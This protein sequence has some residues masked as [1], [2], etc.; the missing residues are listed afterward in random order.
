MKGHGT[1]IV[2]GIKMPINTIIKY[3]HDHF[4]ICESLLHKWLSLTKEEM[5]KVMSGR[6]ITIES[7]RLRTLTELMR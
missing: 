7:D 1:I 5:I 4:L 3:G 2:D 6:E